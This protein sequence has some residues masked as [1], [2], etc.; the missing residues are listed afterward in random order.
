VPADSEAFQAVVDATSGPA[1]T[2]TANGRATV[3]TW[4]VMHERGEPAYAIIYGRLD[5]GTRFIANTPADRD[6]LTEMTQRDFLGVFGDATTQ[7]GQAVFVP[8]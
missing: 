7:D 4:T 2:E 8:R 1:T 3:E 6:L 5:D